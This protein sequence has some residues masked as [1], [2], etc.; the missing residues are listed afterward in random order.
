MLVANAGNMIMVE[1]GIFAHPTHARLDWDLGNSE[2]NRVNR[3]R[4]HYPANMHQARHPSDVKENMIIQTRTPSSI[5]GPVL[6]LTCPLQ[7]NGVNMHILTGLRLRSPTCNKLW[8]TG[9]LRIDTDHCRLGTENL[10]FR[11][12]LT[13]LSSNDILIFVK[14]TQV[15]MLYHF[16]CF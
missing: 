16:S 9:P 13:Q 12:A 14:R 10:R 3:D 8:H 5:C 2:A 4:V 15:L 1:F 6:M 7:V 11:D